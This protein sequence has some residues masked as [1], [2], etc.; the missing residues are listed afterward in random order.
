MYFA[1][2]VEWLTFVYFIQ[3]DQNHHYLDMQILDIS[4]ITREPDLKWVI[5]LPLVIVLYHSD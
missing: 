2:S 4:V 1:I 3:M 5:Y